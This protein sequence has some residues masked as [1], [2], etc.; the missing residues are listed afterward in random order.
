MIGVVDG[1][2]GVCW[3]VLVGVWEYGI[4]SSGCRLWLVGLREEVVIC[5]RVIEIVMKFRD[6]V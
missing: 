4:G 1:E 6:F 5:S 3:F 2:G